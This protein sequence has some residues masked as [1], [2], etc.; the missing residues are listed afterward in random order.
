MSATAY[1][2]VSDIEQVGKVLTAKGKIN[3]VKKVK[4]YF[5]NAGE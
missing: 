5:K 1:M 3:S 2:K 4:N